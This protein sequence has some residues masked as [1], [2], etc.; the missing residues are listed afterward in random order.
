MGHR[1]LLATSFL[2]QSTLCSV[3]S[4]LFWCC[5]VVQHR[6]I[7]IMIGK[8][9]NTNKFFTVNKAVI[10]GKMVQIYRL[11]S[12]PRFTISKTPSIERCSI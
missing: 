3:A 2:L 1:N 4:R 11:I 9:I 12:Q 5:W 6:M 10:N 8:T 7:W